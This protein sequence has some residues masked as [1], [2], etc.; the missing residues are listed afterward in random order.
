MVITESKSKKIFR[1]RGKKI[2]I[3]KI[4]KR[5]DLKEGTV[6]SHCTMKSYRKE[7]NQALPFLEKRSNFKSTAGY[8]P[9]K[10]EPITNVLKKYNRSFDSLII[11]GYQ[12]CD[13]IVD[14]MLKKK[15]KVIANDVR[16]NVFCNYKEIYTIL[17]DAISLKFRKTLD[18]IKNFNPR[19]AAYINLTGGE[20]L[21]KHVFKKGFYPIIAT[22][23][24][25][26]GRNK[27]FSSLE[28][29]EKLG[30]KTYRIAHH[31]FLAIYE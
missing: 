21:I 22:V 20:N 18:E 9:E 2:S 7:L 6:H 24:S 27:K 19:C 13:K 4:A 25:R 14:L 30:F 15:K 3:L 1:M 29:C 16:P 23:S 8:T 11:I 10:I 5:L 31:T 17:M 26:P 28:R 12:N